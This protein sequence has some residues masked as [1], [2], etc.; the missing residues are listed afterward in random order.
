[1][2]RSSLLALS[3]ALL[4]GCAS[5]PEPM[6]TGIAPNP[7]YHPPGP[8]NPTVN[9]GPAVVGDSAW[10]SEATKWI[11]VPFR[12]GGNN[13]EGMDARGLVRRMYE[14]VARIKLTSNVD[15]LTRTGVAIPRDQLRPGDIVFFGKDIGHKVYVGDNP[16][17]QETNITGAGIYLGDNRIVTADPI[18]GVAYAQL[19]DPPYSENY[20]TARRILR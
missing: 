12:P 19:F 7:R 1:M 8:T 5:E 17:H 15:E 16:Y 2:F 3:L 11:G 13:R 9:P 10:Q 18:L 14:N 4:F 6:R 20:L